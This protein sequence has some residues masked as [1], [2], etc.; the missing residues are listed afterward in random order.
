MVHVATYVH[1][2]YVS[3]YVCMCVYV[4]IYMLLVARKGLSW[5][6]KSMENFFRKY[7][8]LFQPLDSI[9]NSYSTCNSPASCSLS[10]PFVRNDGMVKKHLFL[11][12][13]S[14]A[15]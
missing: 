9:F 5:I 4:C 12:K 15:V 2:I 1:Y 11:A 14:L 7:F 6:S 13:R 8:K 10:F 3:M